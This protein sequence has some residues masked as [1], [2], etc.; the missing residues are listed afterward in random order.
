AALL[1]AALE[2]TP[3]P[4]AQRAR[5]LIELGNARR[6][7]GAGELV[8]A[9]FAEAASLAR[10]ADDPGLL[11]RAALGLCSV[12]FFPGHDPVDQLAVELLQE[13]LEALPASELGLR[14][15]VMAQ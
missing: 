11:A 13:G 15:C 3:Y 9:T 5:L 12:P 10:G 1:E 4:G 7:A 14:A 8:R 2:R 6:R